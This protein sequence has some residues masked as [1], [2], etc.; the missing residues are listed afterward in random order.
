MVPVCDGA[1]PGVN[2]TEILSVAERVPDACAPGVPDPAATSSHGTLELAVHDTVPALPC[3]IRTACAPVLD[4]NP[5]PA[6]LR[7][8]AKM[9]AVRSSVIVGPVPFC[10]L[11]TPSKPTAT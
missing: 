3:V 8:P 10:V 1:R 6:L 9:S 2:W 7:T 4:V 11:V 5:A